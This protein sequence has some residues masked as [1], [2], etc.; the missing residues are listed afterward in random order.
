LEARPACPG[1]RPLLPL[2]RVYRV[3][4]IP[5][6][7]GESP[8]FSLGA[9]E[10]LFVVDRRSL[11]PVPVP[12]EA[13]D[14]EQVKTELHAAVVELASGICTGAAELKDVLRDLRLD[15]LGRLSEHG[16]VPVATATWPTAVPE[17]QEIT[18]EEGYLRFVE[19]AGSSARR[20]FCCGLHVHVGVESPE[21]CMVALEHVLPWLPVLLAVSANSP[22]LA[23]R[24]TG[25]ASNRAEILALLPRSGAPPIFDSYTEWER[26]AERLIRLGLADSY[27]R[28]WWDTRPHPAFGTLEVRMPDQ[29]T[30]VETSAA[31]AAVVQA[32]V[33]TAEPDEPADRGMYA[34]NRWAAFRYG[35]RARLMHPDGTRL[36]T[37]PELLAELLE[38]VGPRAEEFGRADVLRPL[39]ELDQATEQL[40][41]GRDEGLETLCRRLIELT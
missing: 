18:P 25:L 15:A 9:E 23:G 21:A 41:L 14:G 35:R 26:F 22:W 29:P 31:F 33:S 16:L 4:V 3:R 36:A 39:V 1:L 30:A 32:L 6:A 24:E 2:T 17:E 8:P 27:R 38:R 19:L 34:E 5:R 11:R 28:I 40:E 13:I 7:F 37:V 10:E 12:P 20:Q